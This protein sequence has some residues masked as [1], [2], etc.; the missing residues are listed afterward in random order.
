MSDTRFKFEDLGDL[1]GL[2][3]MANCLH[4]KNYSDTSLMPYQ[5]EIWDFI[6]YQGHKVVPFICRD[7]QKKLTAK[8]IAVLAMDKMLAAAKANDIQSLKRHMT[9]GVNNFLKFSLGKELFDLIED[10]YKTPIVLIKSAPSDLSPEERVVLGTA[11]NII[12]NS[13]I[14]AGLIRP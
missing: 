13:G 11:G 3:L 1:L 9:E 12:K 7:K 8:D 2:Y 10:G 6:S 5:Q 14:N 4:F